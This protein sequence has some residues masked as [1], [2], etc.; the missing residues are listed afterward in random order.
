MVFYNISCDNIVQY[1]FEFYSVQELLSMYHG[2]HKSNTVIMVMTKSVNIIKTF[3]NICIQSFPA[4]RDILMI[5]SVNDTMYICFPV[6]WQ[7]CHT[8]C[9]GNHCYHRNPGN[10]AIYHDKMVILSDMI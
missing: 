3:R 10:H 1:S 9:Y 5:F 8:Y 6:A 7:F 4:T 2:I